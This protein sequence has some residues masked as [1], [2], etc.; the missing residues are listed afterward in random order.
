[1]RTYIAFLRGINVGGNNII[2]MDAL[3]QA[4]M[5][6]GFT[7]VAT[8]IQSGNVVFVSNKTNCIRIEKQIERV[9]SVR[10][11]YLARVLVREK[12]RNRSNGCAFAKN[13]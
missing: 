9:L 7:E 4:F 13:F 2:K 5:D 1:M 6:M 3:R 12:K 11:A 10:F 8:Y